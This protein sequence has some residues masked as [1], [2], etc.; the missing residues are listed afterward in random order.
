MSLRDISF[1]I[2]SARAD[3][4]LAKIR[5]EQGSQQ[6]FDRLYESLH[7]PWSTAVPY[8]R[9]QLRKYQIV[10]SLLPL[11]EYRRALDIGCGLGV[12]TRLLAPH[13]EQVLGVDVSQYA[14]DYAGR[15]SPGLSNVQYRQADLL[16]LDT[17]QDRQ[18]D[19]VVAA[20]MLYYLPSL[21][22]QVLE[23]ARDQVMA[24][25]APGGT[26]LLVNHYFFQFDR[27]S[28]LTREIH[29]C[30]RGATGLHLIREHRRPFY[31]VSVLERNTD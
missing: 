14:V 19:L 22:H 9:Y 21:S 28:R 17:I 7:D 18:F 12:L 23:T 4:M 2:R 1:W 20:D 3:S 8:Y 26:L 30:F 15:M 16:K 5:H 25:L 13:A 24:L 29:N 31:L 11:R 6:V 27:S 10:I